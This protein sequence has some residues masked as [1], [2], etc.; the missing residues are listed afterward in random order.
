MRAYARVH[1]GERG[2]QSGNNMKFAFLGK[3]RLCMTLG[4]TGWRSHTA[5]SASPNGPRHVTSVVTV[6]FEEK[7]DTLMRQVHPRFALKVCRRRHFESKT[8]DTVW[9]VGTLLFNENCPLDH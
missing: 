9:V 6:A 4:K 8:S 1:V 5:S 2:S 7:Y 3:C